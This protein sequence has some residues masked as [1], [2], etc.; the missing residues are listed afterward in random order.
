MKNIL[1]LN[2]LL[3]ILVS[4]GKQTSVS[5]S[6]GD[7]IGDILSG[8]Q[9]ILVYE[10][11]GTVDTNKET[12]AVTFPTVREAGEKR[13]SP[14]IYLQND[15][16]S[17][18]NINIAQLITDL[19]ATPFTLETTD[20]DKG[21]IGGVLRRGSNST[22]KRCKMQ[23]SYSGS[24]NNESFSF[25]LFNPSQATNQDAGTITLVANGSVDLNT[26]E[27]LLFSI[28]KSSI[29]FGILPENKTRDERIIIS[30]ISSQR[31]VAE[32]DFSL[33]ATDPSI[34]IL[35]ENC[36][37]QIAPE[38]SCFV[39]IRYT[40]DPNNTSASGTLEIKTASNATLVSSVS[41]AGESVVPVDPLAP[42]LSFDSQFD[43][44][45]FFTGY[46]N[47]ITAN[48]EIENI[49]TTPYDFSLN[50]IFNDNA[51]QFQIIENNCENNVSL[52]PGRTCYIRVSHTPEFEQNNYSG[53]TIG[54]GQDAPTF[55]LKHEHWENITYD[56]GVK[57]DSGARYQ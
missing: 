32:P 8:I 50:P 30:N 5:S 16:T 46:G 33:L 10:N 7:S 29:D 57:F 48:V 19:A 37:P 18:V 39:V 31:Q 3:A 56:S 34:Q 28:N 51:T 45:R 44:R 42:K 11:D 6:S 23:F 49:S 25:N 22:A 36:P 17:D 1:F 52:L 26:D 4:C 27:S 21:N 55:E 15:S 43:F 54:S 9:L 40:H 2:L 35:S 38:R 41:L 13:F 47:Q 14:F 53:I 12:K 24:L 20:C